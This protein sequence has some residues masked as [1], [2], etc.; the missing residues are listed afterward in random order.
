[1]IETSEK[2]DIKMAELKRQQETEARL[3][4]VK[5]AIN[6]SPPS[7]L[8]LTVDSSSHHSGLLWQWT[9]L[10]IFLVLEG[11]YCNHCNNQLI[12]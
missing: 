3:Q 4:P 11:E 1:M 12:K 10:V 7:P 9:A 8:T 2:F 6:P 5:D